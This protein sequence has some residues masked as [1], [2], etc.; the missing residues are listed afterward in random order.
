MCSYSIY[1]QGEF[2]FYAVLKIHLEF[3]FVIQHIFKFWIFFKKK[4]FEF[5]N[6]VE[7]IS[8]SQGN[9]NHPVCMYMWALW[10][11]SSEHTIYKLN[12]LYTW[13]YKM[14]NVEG[15]SHFHCALCTSLIYTYWNYSTFSFRFDFLLRCAFH[16]QRFVIFSFFRFFKMS[17]FYF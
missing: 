3:S 14:Q 12:T 11:P 7:K 6:I 2:V 17:S 9:S 16:I 15:A 13:R 8:S 5:R 10:A 1:I 4:L